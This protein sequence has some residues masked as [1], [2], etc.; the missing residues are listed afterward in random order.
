M[1]HVLGF[2]ITERNKS[3]TSLLPNNIGTPDH[4]SRLTETLDN[5]EN[6]WRS[7]FQRENAPAEFGIERERERERERDRERERERERE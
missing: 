1:I 2:A 3:I 4:Q 7:I 6:K 5:R